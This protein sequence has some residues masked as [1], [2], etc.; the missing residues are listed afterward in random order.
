MLKNPAQMKFIQEHDE[1]V[2][3][4]ANIKQEKKKNKIGR[5][6]SKKK[7]SRKRQENLKKEKVFQG[8]K[9]ELMKG[10]IDDVGKGIEHLK[11]LR[12]R[13]QKDILIFT[14]GSVSRR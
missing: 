1:L 8:G 13:R 2:S 6:K 9:N 4:L 3:N 11:V 7:R 10:M 5:K 12:N 14:M